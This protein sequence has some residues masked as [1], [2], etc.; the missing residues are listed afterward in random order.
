M[1]ELLLPDWPAPDRVWAASTTRRGGVGTGA[2]ASLNLSYGSGDDLEA[3]TENRRRLYRALAIDTPPVW[4][5]QVHGAAVVDAAALTEP[6]PADACFSR[7]SG[8]V[9]LVQTA[10]CLPVLLCDRNGTVVAAAH[11]GWRGLAR[12]VLAAVVNTMACPPADLMAWLGPAIGPGA[13]EIGPEVRAEFL[14]WDAGSADCFRPGDGD[15][16]MADIYALARRQLAALG[17]TAVYGGDRC[18]VSEPE[19]FFSY[20]RDGRYSGRMATLIGLS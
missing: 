7:R 3:V 9:C 20:R 18:T 15:R 10:D 17:V 14:D 19:W 6:V 2:H 4:L 11:A 12:G 1:V 5:R 13:F 8:R 16:W